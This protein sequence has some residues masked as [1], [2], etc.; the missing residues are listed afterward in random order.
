MAKRKVNKSEAVRELIAEGKGSPKEIAT[1]LNKKG[2][3]VSAAYVSN[4]KTQMS[5]KGSKVTKGR[6]GRVAA[7]AS[8]NGSATSNGNGSSTAIMS[9]VDLV[10][11]VGPREAHKMVDVA[12]NMITRVAKRV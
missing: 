5:K 2:V 7:S 10:L 11:H 4:I 6:R 1:L 9:A 3:K 8:T 12:N